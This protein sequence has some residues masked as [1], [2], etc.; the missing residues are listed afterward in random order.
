MPTNDHDINQHDSH[1]PKERSSESPG[2]E[3]TDVNINGV[4]VF[5][6]GLGASSSS[7]LSFA[8]SWAR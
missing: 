7:S 4:I 3:T 1:N 2:Y 8:S 5:L 6:A